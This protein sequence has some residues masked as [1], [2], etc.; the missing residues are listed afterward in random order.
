MKTNWFTHL[1]DRSQ[2]TS[3]LDSKLFFNIYEP[4]ISIYDMILHYGSDRSIYNHFIVWPSRP[5][6]ST[7]LNKCF[8]CTSTPQ[9]EQLCQIILK[10]MH[11]CTCYGQD[12]LN[13][14]PI[15]HLNFKCEL[16]LHGTWTN[17]SNGTSTHQRG[18]LCQIIAKSMHK[19]SSYALD[20]YRWT[21]NAQCKQ[22][23][24]TPTEVVTTM[25][26]SLQVGSTKMLVHLL[27]NFF[28]ASSHWSVHTLTDCLP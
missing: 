19:C 16:D 13:L 6:P 9:G 11:K 3:Y 21:H 1:L 27:S 10:S 5:W 4:K 24:H 22:N 23:A 7:Y 14:W 8:N 18:Q 20:K 17:V 12:K 2:T 28:F 26:G 25:S 15:Y